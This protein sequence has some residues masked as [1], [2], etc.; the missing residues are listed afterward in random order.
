M[1]SGIIKVIS[2]ALCGVSLPGRRAS[3]EHMV[4]HMKTGNGSG[5]LMFGRVEEMKTNKD[6]FPKAGTLQC[7]VLQMFAGLV[8]S[9]WYVCMWQRYQW[10][11]ICIFPVFFGNGTNTY[12]GTWSY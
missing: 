2:K 7:T 1:H 10:A 12:L 4:S 9:L 3:D 11:P 5:R 8:F 6:G